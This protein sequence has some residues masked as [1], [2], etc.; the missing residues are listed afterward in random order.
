MTSEKRIHD[1]QNN[2]LTPSW[3]H[4]IRESYKNILSEEQIEETIKY[5]KNIFSIENANAFHRGMKFVADYLTLGIRESTS[6]KDDSSI[7]DAGY[8][9]AVNE[10]RALKNE[11]MSIIVDK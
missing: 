10:L 3:E 4:H 1:N 8:N 2:T 6:S 7:K 9:E 11:A 5:W